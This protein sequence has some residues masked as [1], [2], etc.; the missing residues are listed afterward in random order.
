[1]V[2]LDSRREDTHFTGPAAPA[3]TWCVFYGA[4]KPEWSLRVGVVMYGM[5][6]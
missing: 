5:V 3:D 6:H 1:M 4:D 2:K